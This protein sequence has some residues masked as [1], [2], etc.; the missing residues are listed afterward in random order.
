MHAH[1]TT[2]TCM[3]TLHRTA[4]H[5]IRT[6]M[7][8][9]TLHCTAPHAP[10][11]TAP[12]ACTHA[13]THARV[14]MR[15]C[16]RACAQG[17]MTYVCVYICACMHMHTRV[18]DAS[19]AWVAGDLQ[20]LLHRGCTGTSHGPRCMAATGVNK[21]RLGRSSKRIKRDARVCARNGGL[22]FKVHSDDH[23]CSGLAYWSDIYVVV[24]SPL[25]PSTG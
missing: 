23:N 7:H 25:S 10:H 19:V 9:T 22:N 21:A 16:M 17:C 15:A 14:C 20:D 2:R 3:H 13:P 11:R 8:C 24:V 1:A 5:R 4:P 18:H 6:R 12:H